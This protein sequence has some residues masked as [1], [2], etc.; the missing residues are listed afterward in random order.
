MPYF[1]IDAAETRHG[2]TGT[3]RII[4]MRGPASADGSRNRA[5]LMFSPDIAAD[6]AVPVGYLTGASADGLSM[7]AW[8][9]ACEHE[10]HRRIV[11]A[12]GALGV[13][14]ETRDG[15]DGYLRR[16]ALGHAEAPLR[17]VA[18]RMRR[19]APPAEAFAMPL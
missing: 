11:D 14:Y 13:H 1:A 6:A 16:I 5:R 10:A 4:E 19:P 17:G 18:T 8:L 9:P 15:R 3:T 7:I 12:G 2:R